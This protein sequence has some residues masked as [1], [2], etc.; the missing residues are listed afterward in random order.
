MTGQEFS[1]ALEVGLKMRA[2]FVC[3]LK[4]LEF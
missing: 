2:G 3:I 1:Q 4:T